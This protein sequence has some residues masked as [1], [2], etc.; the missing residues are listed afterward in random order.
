M[1]MQYFMNDAVR[2]Y[3]LCLSS[4]L[5]LC[6]YLKDCN[7]LL[8]TLLHCTTQLSLHAKVAMNIMIHLNCVALQV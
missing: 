4:A 7:K 5:Q 3:V 8:Y 1:H 6:N 2:G